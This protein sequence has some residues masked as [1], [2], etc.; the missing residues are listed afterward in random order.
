VGR[1][2]LEAGRSWGSGIVQS[3]HVERK[4]RKEAKAASKNCPVRC[5]GSNLGN[6]VSAEEGSPG[7]E[8]R[9]RSSYGIVKKS[10]EDF[11]G[12][13]EKTHGENK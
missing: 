4:I 5:P 8:W 11:E 1:G 6:E 7:I 10:R 13:K 12:G 3:S 9:D 2:G